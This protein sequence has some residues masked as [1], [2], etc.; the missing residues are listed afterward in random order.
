ME[1]QTPQ[2]I[3]DRVLAL[4]EGARVQ[5]LGPVIRGRKGEYVEL[6]RQP[7]TQGFSRARVDGETYGLDAPPTLDKQRKHTIEVV[8]D[9]L[10]VTSSSK[11]RRAAARAGAR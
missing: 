2:Q 1:R 10:A 8:V 4:E 7:Q 9:P 3:V 6:F 11:R 5:V